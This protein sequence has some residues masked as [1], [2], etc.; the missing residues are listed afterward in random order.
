MS[1]L[2]RINANVRRPDLIAS[3]T[4][5]VNIVVFGWIPH[6]FV[7]CPTLREGKHDMKYESFAGKQRLI[8]QSISDT[9]DP[10]EKKEI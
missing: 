9:V 6:K 10:V 3:E 1:Y 4:H 7:V 2:R 8:T 5:F